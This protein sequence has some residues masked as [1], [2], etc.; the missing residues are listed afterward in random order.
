MEDLTETT[1][2]SLARTYRDFLYREGYRP[3]IDA[4][5]DV[6]FKAEGLFCFIDV[7]PSDPT[8]LRVVVPNIWSLDDEQERLRAFR[9][10]NEVQ[11]ELK[12]LKITFA[13][14]DDTWIATEVFLEDE[15]AFENTLMRCV[16]VLLI[17]VHRFRDLMR[18]AS[19][20]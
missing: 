20:S 8:Y 12:G 4:D 5:G 1:A 7:T 6:T 9:V 18:A 11:R 19:L 17:G 15:D 2:P 14:H 3:E 13:P 10:A 16:R